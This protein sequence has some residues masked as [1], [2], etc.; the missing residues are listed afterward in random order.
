MSQIEMFFAKYGP[1][2]TLAQL[3]GVLNRSPEGLRISLRGS[4]AFS[5][6]VNESRVKL[7]RRVYFSVPKIAKILGLSDGH[8]DLYNQSVFRRDN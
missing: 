6:K 4:D 8:G 2:I 7:G 5:K 3:A 1:L